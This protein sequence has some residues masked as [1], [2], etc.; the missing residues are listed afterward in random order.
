[1]SGWGESNSRL[2][3]PNREFYRY[4]TPRIYRPE[5]DANSFTRAFTTLFPTPDFKNLSLYKASSLQQKF[6]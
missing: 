3:V 2:T 1:M 5:G 6:S 4:T